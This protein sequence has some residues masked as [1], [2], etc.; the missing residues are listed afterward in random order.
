[1]ERLT[2]VLIPLAAL[3]LGLILGQQTARPVA[4]PEPTAVV[5]ASND[6]VPL[7]IAAVAVAT[8][9][10]ASDKLTPYQRGQLIT[11]CYQ[12]ASD[13]RDAVRGSS[14]SPANCMIE[15]GKLP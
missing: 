7:P 9:E 14:G 13:Y 10:P 4:F 8:V 12:A 15:I 6:A 5:A 11:A 2:S 1:M 3:L